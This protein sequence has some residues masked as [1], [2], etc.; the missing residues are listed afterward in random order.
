MQIWRKF[1][2]VPPNPETSSNA[3]FRRAY[4]A[5]WGRENAVFYAAT[6]RWECAPVTAPLTIKATVRGAS[7]FTINGRRV[8]LDDDH[9]VVL[10]AGDTYGVS[11]RSEQPVLGFSINVRPGLAQEVAAGLHVSLEQALHDGSAARLEPVRFSGHLREHDDT[12][13][14]A[15]HAI[16]NAVQ[17]GITAPDWY[18]E[19]FAGLV[20][21]LIETERGRARLADRLDGVRR[22]TREELLKRVGWATDFINS[23]YM[24]P[25]SLDDVAREASLSKF[26][27][28]RLFR[29]A[30]GV[31]PHQYLQRKRTRVARRLIDTTDMELADI[32][33]AA[34][35]GSRWTMY[36][37]L[38]R[39]FGACGRGLRRELELRAAP[40]RDA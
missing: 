16:R 40:G 3:A 9:F 24:E 8:L 15:L 14:P 11:I 19:A 38:R 36:R 20:A 2:D 37:F 22:S 30:L 27:L 39:S 35:F 28:A 5:R 29:Q 12:I 25:I 6:R 10:N 33:A 1:A 32:A 26:H 31:T 18:E 23:S 4:F 13:T 17:S 21:R 7:W 34:G